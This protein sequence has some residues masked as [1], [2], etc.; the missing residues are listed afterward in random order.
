MKAPQ[1]TEEQL[2]RSV[3]EYLQV[4]APWAYHRSKFIWHSIPN[5]GKRGKAQTGRLKGMGLRGG[6]AD[7]VFMAPM[8]SE[9]VARAYIEL[10]T[11][12]G[13]QTLNQREFE[14]DCQRLSVPYAVCRSREEVQAQLIAWG[15]V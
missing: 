13:K 14:A 6:V 7:F 10:K 8:S 9:H 15:L 11:A 5:E 2:Q 1:P 12:K 4:V 3:V